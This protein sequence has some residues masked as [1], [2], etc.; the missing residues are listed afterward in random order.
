MPS[1]KRR[2]EKPVGECKPSK[3]ELFDKIAQP[4]LTGDQ[5]IDEAIL[6]CIKVMTAKNIDYSTALGSGDRL[7]NFKKAG[8]DLG[9]PMEQV[10]WTYLWKHWAAIT[11]Y[12]KDGKVD[13]EGIKGRIVDGINYLLILFKMVCERQHA[14]EEKAVSAVDAKFLKELEI[15]CEQRPAIN[16]EN[17][18]AWSDAPCFICTCMPC[19]CIKY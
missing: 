4:R 3:D 19:V 14:E 15:Y 9:L 17:P 13:S 10:L 18:S 8:E 7:Y 6:E 11:R 1:D 16:L 2:Y 5:D 12:C